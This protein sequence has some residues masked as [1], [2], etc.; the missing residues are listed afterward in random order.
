MSQFDDMASSSIFLDVVLFLL[1][2]LVT[3]PSF[4][5]VSSLVLELEQF[6]FIRDDKKF[7][8]QKYPRQCL[9]Q[10]LETVELGIPPWYKFL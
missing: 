7:G 5:S 6:F 10:Y 1:S 8:N 4:M 9:A 2:S 3:G